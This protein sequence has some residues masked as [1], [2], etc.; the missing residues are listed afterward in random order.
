MKG[1]WFCFIAPCKACLVLVSGLWFTS[2]K[3]KTN[4]DIKRTSTQ[5]WTKEVKNKAGMSDKGK[6]QVLGSYKFLV[7]ESWQTVLLSWSIKEMWC[8]LRGGVIGWVNLRLKKEFDGNKQE[9][10]DY[11]FFWHRCKSATTVFKGQLC[12]AEDERFNRRSVDNDEVNF[13]FLISSLSTLI[14]HILWSL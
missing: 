8:F 5:K 7:W 3:V 4:S 6:K 9:S 2:T 1:T 13:V 14:Y 10:S 11:L 12:Q